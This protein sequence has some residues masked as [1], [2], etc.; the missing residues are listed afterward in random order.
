MSS[1]ADDDGD[2]Y[3][4]SVS[5][6]MAGL[7][8][9]FLITLV[10]FVINFRI[11]TDEQRAARQEAVDEKVQALEEK[12]RAEAERDAA[13]AEK[14]RLE[15]V[16]DDLTNARRLRSQM[17]EDIRKRLEARGIRVEIDHDHG[18]LRLSE[19]AISFRSSQAELRPQEQRKLAQIG[20]VL[21]AVLPCYAVNGGTDCDAHTRGKLEAV[22]IEGHTDNVPL[23]RGAFDDNWDLSA[24]R[25]MYTY[26]LLAERHLERLLAW[27]RAA[28][29]PRALRFKGERTPLADGLLLPFTDGNPG[30]SVAA[31]IK[32]FLLDILGD[33]RLTGKQR[34]SGVD[35]RARQVML[36][37]LVTETLEDFFRLLEY[38]AQS[39]AI[40]RRH[41]NARKT[42]WSRYLEAGAIADAWVALGPLARI[43]AR[44]MLSGS[45]DTYAVLKP[46]YNVQKNHSA[47]ILR[48][49]QLMITEWS[50]SGSFRAW[51]QDASGCPK[52]YQSDYTRSKL[53]QTAE[54]TIA[55]HS[56]W[57][58]R[59]ADLIYD[60]TGIYP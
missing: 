17:L 51:R 20:A 31:P 45:G 41:W 9:V 34:W 50:H 24:Q 19:N 29:D 33:P 4:I 1:G 52:L 44:G 7:L 27:S 57:Q 36:G 49:G 18:V 60:Q 3:L 38:A 2:G 15:S 21:M 35:P 6:M 59:V 54:H 25:A 56:G 46:G 5:D 23:Q 22:F 11:A 10:A 32:A 30:P 16:R 37:W 28:D 8:F 55:H 58:A 40:A 42:F 53:V 47:I 13:Q 48:I 14:D 43:E 39:D 26:R 12:E